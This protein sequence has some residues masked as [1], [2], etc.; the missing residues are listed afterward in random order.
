MQKLGNMKRACSDWKKACEL[1]DCSNWGIV[2][3]MRCFGKG[4]TAALF[5]GVVLVG[6]GGLLIRSHFKKKYM[7]KALQEAQEKL[8]VEGD[9]IFDGVL[10]IGKIKGG[11]LDSLATGGTAHLTIGDTSYKLYRKG[12]TSRDFLLEENGHVLARAQSLPGPVFNIEYKGNYYILK[13]KPI[14]WWRFVLRRTFILLHRNNQIGTVRPLS[15]SSSKAIVDLPESMPVTVR[16][17]IF[18]LV[19]ATVWSTEV[20][21]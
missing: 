6:L 3:K 14:P 7:R 10:L 16:V 20:R 5:F 8:R 11:G 4:T 9:E 18:W 1:G 19:E 2:N 12:W 17:F 13:P 21:G 15:W